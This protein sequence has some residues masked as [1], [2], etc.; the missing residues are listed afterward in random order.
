MIARSM[1]R[2]TVVLD[3]GVLAEAMRRSGL[4]SASA[5][6]RQALEDFVGRL[7]A[8][9]ILDFRGSGVWE[10]DLGRMRGD[11]PKRRKR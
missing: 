1:K 2:T 6:V 10:G 9:R 7:R 8:R 5:V 4:P 11:R 3:E